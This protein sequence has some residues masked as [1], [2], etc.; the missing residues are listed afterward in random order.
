MAFRRARFLQSDLITVHGALRVL[1]CASMV[2]LA[3]VSSFHLSS[4]AWS[5]ELSFHCL[6]G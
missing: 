1:Q 3:F 6:S 5:I 4:E 2:F